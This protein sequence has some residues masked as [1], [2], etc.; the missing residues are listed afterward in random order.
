MNRL[1][2]AL[3]LDALKAVDRAECG[4]VFNILDCV[5]LLFSPGFCSVA[6]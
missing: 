2:V 1:Q 3:S 5:F 6:S 4:F